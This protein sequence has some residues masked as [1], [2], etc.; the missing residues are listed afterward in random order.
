MIRSILETMGVPKV[1]TAY[2]DKALDAMFQAYKK[3]KSVFYVIAVQEMVV[4]CGGI[5][6]LA[7]YKGDICELQKMYVS[8]KHRRKGL[9]KE[10]L[11]ACMDSAKVFGFKGCYLETMPYMEAAQRLYLKNGFQY[12]QEPLGSTGHT[13]CTVRMLKEL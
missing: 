1:G 8:R 11:Q 7:N 10:I 6:P 12:L 4:A 5:A 9:A 3:P 2:A 13:A